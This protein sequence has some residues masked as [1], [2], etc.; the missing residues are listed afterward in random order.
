MPSEGVYATAPAGYSLWW[1]SNFNAALP[2]PADAT[3]YYMPACISTN[4]GTSSGFLKSVIPY[5]GT[6]T[7]I[8]LAVLVG[9]TPGSSEAV[10]I[11]L[12]VNN[13]SKATLTS[14]ITFDQS[15]NTWKTATY[16]VSVPIVKGDLVEIKITTPTWAT[17]PIGVG[18]HLFAFART[19]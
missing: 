2:T 14:S 4:P 7:D 11:E 17:N 3:A 6:I 10:T 19:N 13:V 16:T 12:M 9:A 5:E 18:Y 1:S 8:T 15:A